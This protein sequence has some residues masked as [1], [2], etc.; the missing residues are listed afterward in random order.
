MNQATGLVDAQLQQLLETVERHRDER[1][2]VLQDDADAQAQM[3]L[4]HAWQE[5]RARL[6]Q[7]VLATREQARR[8]LAAAQAQHQTRLR[9]QRQHDDQALLA[10]AWQPLRELLLQRWQQPES[11]RQWTEALLTQ[12]SATLLDPH[13]R[14]EHPA[15]WPEAERTAVQRKL[16]AE[17][18]H[19]P[20]LSANTDLAAGLR[21]CAGDACIDGSAS[22]L[23]RART[24]IEAMML[25]ALNDCRRTPLV[26]DTPDVN[27]PPQTENRS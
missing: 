13:W 18:G 12:A 27:P 5:G 3:L 24:H 8:Q 15:D 9:M 23:L 26:T 10:R 6:H 1:C 20:V 2:K 17:L 21:I 16:K 7:A 11:R 4:K 19:D 14:I 25:A 22:G